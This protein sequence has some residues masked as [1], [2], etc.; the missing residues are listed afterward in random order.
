MFQ[1]NIADCYCGQIHQR[2]NKTLPVL[3]GKKESTSNHH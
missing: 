2:I 1:F 3:T